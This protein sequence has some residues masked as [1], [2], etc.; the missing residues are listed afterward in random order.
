MPNQK[1]DAA[2]NKV[3]Q[4]KADVVASRDAVDILL[5]VMGYP[6]LLSKKALESLVF[7]ER[8]AKAEKERHA[9]PVL[10]W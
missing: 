9:K 1:T 8:K 10:D 6:P 5:N 4:E 3:R 2:K 7:R